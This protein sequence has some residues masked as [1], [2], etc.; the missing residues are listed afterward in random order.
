MAAKSGN[1]TASDK[2]FKGQQ[3]EARNREAIRGKEA[4]YQTYVELGLEHSNA[5]RSCM[6][7][8]TRQRAYLRNRTGY[9]E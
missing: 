7:N 8:I 1:K 4:L 2:R 3:G 9:D 5:A 6:R